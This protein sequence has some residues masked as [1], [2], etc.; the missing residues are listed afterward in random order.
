MRT[1]GALAT[2]SVIAIALSACAFNGSLPDRTDHF[3]A[4]NRS[5]TGSWW[6]EPTEGAPS[7]ARE[8]AESALTSAVVTDQMWRDAKS[9]LASSSD[10]GLDRLE[11]ESYVLAVTS[12]VKDELA[13]AGYPDNE[14][15]LEIK[16][17][18]ECS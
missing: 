1:A 12:F 2:T 11:S 14:R 18:T 3:E 17:Q 6:L 16:S 7:E 4:D 8:V 9:V 13:D 15:V 10:V 5:C